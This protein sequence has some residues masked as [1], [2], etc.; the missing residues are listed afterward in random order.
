VKYQFDGSDAELFKDVIFLVRA[1]S[2]EE[3]CLWQHFAHD[4]PHRIHQNVCIN[5]KRRNPGEL[6]QIGEL[7][8]RPICA[9]VSYVY[10]NDKLVMFYDG[11]SQLVDWAMIDAWVEHYTLKTVRYDNGSRWAHCKAANFHHLFDLVGARA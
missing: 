10:L 4:S 2:E 5:W 1:S 11:T 8:R 3:F 6:V 7:D 9:S